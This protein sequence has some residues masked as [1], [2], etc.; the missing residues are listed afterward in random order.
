MIDKNKRL[1]YTKRRQQ[2]TIRRAMATF[3][4]HTTIVNSKAANRIA[5]R[6]SHNT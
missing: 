6:R 1:K 2:P 3:I 4:I 5:A